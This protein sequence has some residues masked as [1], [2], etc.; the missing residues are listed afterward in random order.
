VQNKEYFLPELSR[1]RRRHSPPQRAVHDLPFEA[2][3]KR[4]RSEFNENRREK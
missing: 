1:N 4:A 3:F 2:F